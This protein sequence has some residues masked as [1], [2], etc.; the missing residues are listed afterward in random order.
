MIVVPS[1]SIQRGGALPSWVA[2][3]TLIA[4]PFTDAVYD[5]RLSI[6]AYSGLSVAAETA[7]SCAIACFFADCA[8]GTMNSPMLS[9]AEIRLTASGQTR[10]SA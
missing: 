6:A 5:Q 4:V 2:A 10:L 1:H 3:T 8:S 9:L 7:H